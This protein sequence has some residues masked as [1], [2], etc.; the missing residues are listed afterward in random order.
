MPELLH[1]YYKIRCSD[2]IYILDSV[3]WDVS[4]ADIILYC[5]ACPLGLAFW[6]PQYQCGFQYLV[7]P[8]TEEDIWFLESLAVLSALVWALTI[9]P[10]QPKRVVI[11]TDNTNTVDMFN[12]LRTNPSHNPILITAVNILLEQNADLRVMHIPGEM[13]VVADCL[14]RFN[15]TG[16]TM[17]VPGLQTAPFIPP[18]LSLGAVIQ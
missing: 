6:C 13:N 7:D 17:L 9:A 11:F 15:N 8:T 4:A 10:C 16:A 5:D 14:S 12:S 18:H 1:H 3:E 2:G